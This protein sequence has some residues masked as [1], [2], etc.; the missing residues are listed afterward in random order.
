MEKREIYL[1]Y[2]NAKSI[3]EFNR[4][5]EIRINKRIKDVK[6]GYWKKFINDNMIC[7]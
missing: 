2:R 6:K 3:K 5:K 7:R 4:Y 1:K